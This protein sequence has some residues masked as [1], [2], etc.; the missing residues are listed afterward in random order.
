MNIEAIRTW[1]IGSAERARNLVLQ[2]PTY[3]TRLRKAF[4]WNPLAV[5]EMIVGVGMMFGL[6]SGE[7]LL[8]FDLGLVGGGIM[9]DGLSRLLY[10]KSMVPLMIQDFLA[11]IRR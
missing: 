11:F 1:G 8:R 2:A 5:G 10:G 7:N 6:G 9:L 4:H 3:A